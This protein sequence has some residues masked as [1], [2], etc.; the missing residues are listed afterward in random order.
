MHEL[1]LHCGSC[2]SHKCRQ[3]GLTVKD[4]CT[5][6]SHREAASLAPTFGSPWR[7]RGLVVVVVG[8]TDNAVVHQREWVWAALLIEQHLKKKE[9]VKKKKWRSSSWEN[10]SFV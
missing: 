8:G 3:S 5:K 10:E 9:K 2:S 1:W 7:G 6:A 4:K